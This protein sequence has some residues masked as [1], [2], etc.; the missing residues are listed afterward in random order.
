MSE[1]QTEIETETEIEKKIETESKNSNSTSNRSHWT[2]KRGADWEQNNILHVT[3][4]HSPPFNYQ[5]HLPTR[6][7]FPFTYLTYDKSR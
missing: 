4:L 6:K 5:F 2:P 3:L 7:Y 1:G